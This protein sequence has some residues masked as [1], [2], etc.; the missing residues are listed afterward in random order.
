[1]HRIQ[2][3]ALAFIFLL[4]ISPLP[5]ATLTVDL[6]GGAD[7]TDIQSAIDAAKDGDTVVIGEFAL[8]WSD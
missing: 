2:D 6:D 5:A 8:E 3:L 4:I 1:M 7:Y